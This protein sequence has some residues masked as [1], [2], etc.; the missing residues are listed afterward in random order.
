MQIWR[1]DLKEV[2][3]A[4][5]DIVEEGISGRAQGSPTAVRAGRLGE[6]DLGRVRAA[7]ADDSE[8]PQHA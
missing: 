4:K 7:L 8:D 2:P 1:Q 6:V 3:E 5:V